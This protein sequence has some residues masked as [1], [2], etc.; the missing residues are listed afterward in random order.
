MV[1][2][3][4]ALEDADVLMKGVS[5]TLKN[6]AQKGGALPILPMLLGTLGSSLIGNLLTGREMYRIGSNKCNCGQG[7]YRTGAGM[8]RSGHGLFRTGQGIKNKE[9]FLKIQNHI[10]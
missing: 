10:L 3:V 6:D 8:F 4:K 2:F 7:I 5:E 1:K 9:I